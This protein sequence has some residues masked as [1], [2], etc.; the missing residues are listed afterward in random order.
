[1]C[2]TDRVTVDGHKMVKGPSVDER[3]GDQL[4]TDEDDSWFTHLQHTTN[5]KQQQTNKQTTHLYTIGLESVLEIHEEVRGSLL[6]SL[7]QIY[8]MPTGLKRVLRGHPTGVRLSEQLRRC[9]TKILNHRLVA[10]SLSRVFDL[11]QV[12]SA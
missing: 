4:C 7:P 11:I 2:L 6:T 1:M 9:L 12:N 10:S 8:L 5:S 3:A